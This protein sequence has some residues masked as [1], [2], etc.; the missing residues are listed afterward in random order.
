M[1]RVG[2]A[3]TAL[4]T[5]GN[6]AETQRTPSQV[7]LIKLGQMA[8]GWTDF[9]IGNVIER[10]GRADN[11]KIRMNSRIAKIE[12]HYVQCISGESKRRKRRGAGKLAGVAPNSDPLFDE[13]SG[14]QVRELS[15]DPVR[16]NSQIYINMKAWVALNMQDCRHAEKHYQKLDQMQKKWTGVF[17]EVLQKISSRRG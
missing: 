12:K 1:V 9:F 2:V 5:L 8:E 16:S 17:D 14:N 13:G 7:I 11:F 10:P 6:S 3:I 4:T 15:N